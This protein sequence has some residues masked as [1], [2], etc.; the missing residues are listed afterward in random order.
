M[1]HVH[2][3]RGQHGFVGRQQQGGG[4][5]VGQAIRR[6]GEQIGG[7]RGDD[8]RDRPA[9]DNSIWPISVSSVSENRSS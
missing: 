9:R 8:D 3:R 7:G 2:R 1:R 4:Q 5:I 6:L